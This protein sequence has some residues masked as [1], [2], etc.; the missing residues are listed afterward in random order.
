MTDEAARAEASLSAS[1][2][3]EDDEPSLDEADATSEV[4]QL[5]TLGAL[6][7]PTGENKDRTLDE[8]AAIGEKGWKWLSWA[9]EDKRPWFRDG[10][11]HAEFGAAVREYVAL[12][13]KEQ[14]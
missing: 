6:K 11:P 14:S 1:S 2:V 9:C 4:D 3:P 12:R 8:I 10:H 13:S 5:A 7:P